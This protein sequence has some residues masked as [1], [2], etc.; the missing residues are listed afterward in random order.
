MF[1]TLTIQRSALV[2]V[3]AGAVVAT[4]EAQTPPPDFER[5]GYCTGELSTLTGSLARFHI[6]L[7]DDNTEPG[8]FVVMRFIDHNGTVIRSKTANISAGRST[9]LEHRGTSILYRVQ[10]DVYESR[11]LINP[12]RRRTVLCSEEKEV[13]INTAAGALF[14]AAGD[15]GF[16][17]IGPG[18]IKYKSVNVNSY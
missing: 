13:S 15:K 1:R 14:T 17:L 3:L 16:L 2:L 4:S 18:P 7:D 12:S 8:I 9:T 11:D 10:A 5:T 6:A